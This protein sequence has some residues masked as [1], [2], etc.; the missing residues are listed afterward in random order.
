MGVKGQRVIYF[1]RAVG[2]NFVKVGFTATP[3]EARLNGL[4]TGCPFELQ[5]EAVIPGTLQHEQQ[6]LAFLRRN[7]LQA[8]VRGEWFSLSSV[9]VKELAGALVPAAPPP[10]PPDVEVALVEIKCQA[11]RTLVEKLLPTTV[12]TTLVVQQVAWTLLELQ[13]EVRTFLDAV[14]GPG[15]ESQ[16]QKIRAA[17]EQRTH[18]WRVAAAEHNAFLAGQHPT[19]QTSQLPWRDLDKPT[20]AGVG[21]QQLVE[22]FNHVKLAAK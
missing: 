8:H 21:S 13:E 15:L 19:Q 14:S 5:V 6:L 3:V 20:E 9:E 10:K 7:R 16:A 12:A 1:L 4:Q 22:L 11:A 17:Y 18:A 2:T